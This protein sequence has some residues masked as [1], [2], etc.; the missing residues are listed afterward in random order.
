MKRLN[1]EIMKCYVVSTY[2]DGYYSDYDKIIKDYPFIKEYNYEPIPTIFRYYDGR[3]IVYNRHQ[4]EIN[5]SDELYAFMNECFKLGKE[6][7]VKKED[8][9][10]YIT[11]EIYDDWR[12]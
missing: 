1:G 9:D 8:N 3:E 6:V 12:E 2:Y 7:I 10:T 5:N 4:I 11:L